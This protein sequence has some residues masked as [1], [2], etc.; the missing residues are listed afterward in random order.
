L[1][2]PLPPLPLVA[3]PPGLTPP[4]GL[5]EVPGVV[6]LVAAGVEVL[7]VV[8]L[9]VVVGLL[10]AVELLVD[11]DAVLVDVDVVLVDVLEL[12]QSLAASS[13]T[14]LAPWLRF[15]DRVVLMVDGRLVTALVSPADAL[16]AAPHWWASTAAETE[17]SWLVRL[18]F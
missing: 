11:V 14:V 10:V 15:C 16:A 2:L 12:L 6:G 17:L 9:D 1:P 7:V 3:V 13:A 4:L 18:W 5:E 8:L